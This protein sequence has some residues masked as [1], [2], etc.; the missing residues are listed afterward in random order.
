[1]NVH[2]GG[3]QPKMHDTVMPNGEPQSM[4]DSNGVPKGLKLV[5]E[6]RGVDTTHMVR[7]DMVKVLSEFQDF[8]EERPAVYTYLVRVMKYR[9]IFLPKVNTYLRFISGAKATAFKTSLS[10]AVSS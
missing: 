4:V 9:C 7:E 2:P 8:R 5:L 1:M 6:E 10:H 3:K